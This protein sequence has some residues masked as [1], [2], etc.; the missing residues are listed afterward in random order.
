[1]LNRKQQLFVLAYVETDNASE[2]ARRAGYAV[3]SAHVQGARLLRQ[4]EIKQAVELE[5]QATAKRFGI[6]KD[7][8]VRELGAIA[9]ADMSKWVDGRT[10]ALRTDSRATNDPQYA[11]MASLMKDKLKAMDQLARLLGLNEADQ[12]EHKHIHVHMDDQE[13]ARRLLGI[14]TRAGK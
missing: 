9:F 12:A 1:M 3:A 5:R 11:A 10:G 6:N 14:L 4:V 8:M 7:R 13:R 2:A